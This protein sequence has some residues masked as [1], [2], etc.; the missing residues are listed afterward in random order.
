MKLII[1]QSPL[2]HTEKIVRQVSFMN[3][4]MNNQADRYTTLGY[5]IS[6]RY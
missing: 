6:K 4:L 5:G 2:H 1:I 3:G